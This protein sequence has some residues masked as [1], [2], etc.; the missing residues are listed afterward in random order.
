[1][2]DIFSKEVAGEIIERINKLNS[3]TQ[4]KWG[5]MS[6]EEMLAHCNVTYE[7]AFTDKHPKPNGFV[8]LML[9]AFVKN[10]VVGDK[11]YKKNS[12]TAPAFKISDKRVFET[13]KERL[14]GFVN[15]TQL[16]GRAA[17]EG[18]ESNSFGKLTAN[19]WNVMF[20][21]HL[22]HHLTQFGV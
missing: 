22:D 17:F 1:M 7:M 15:Q 4:P 20:Y 8:K 18:K 12:Q 3:A 11:P 6:V 10:T 19:E 2:K 13:E 21:K 16:A 9:K 14:I 5:K